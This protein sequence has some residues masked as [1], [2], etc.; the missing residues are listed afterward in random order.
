MTQYIIYC[1]TSTN[2]N[3]KRQIQ[4]I[5]QYYVSDGKIRHYLSKTTFI[6][7]LKF[8]SLYEIGNNLKKLKNLNGILGNSRQNL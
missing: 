5:K 7:S 8:P 6:W 3:I 2:I 4:I 1:H